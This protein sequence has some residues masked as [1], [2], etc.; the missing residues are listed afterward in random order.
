MISWWWLWPT[1]SLAFLLGWVLC[2]LITQSSDAA[3]ME[4][5]EAFLADC[6]RNPYL[7]ERVLQDIARMLKDKR[8]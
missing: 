1:A 8:E 5:Y 2:A 7:S 3:M 4:E 6:R